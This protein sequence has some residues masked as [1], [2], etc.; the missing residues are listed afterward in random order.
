MRTQADPTSVEIPRNNS[1]CGSLGAWP[2]HSINAFVMQ[3]LLT[4]TTEPH[5]ELFRGISTEVGSAC[6]LIFHF[7]FE[8]DSE[9]RLQWLNDFDF[10]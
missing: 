4:H 2:V 1:K 9:S 8:Y 5:F 10:H 6:V 7:D 3:E